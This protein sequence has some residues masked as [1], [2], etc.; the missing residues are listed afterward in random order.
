MGTLMFILNKADSIRNLV[1]SF[2][3]P[4]IFNESFSTWLGYGMN[5]VAI[6]ELVGLYGTL[7]KL[8][9]I[10]AFLMSCAAL[11]ATYLDLYDQHIE[12]FYGNC[13]AEISAI[14]PEKN[15]LNIDVNVSGYEP[16][17]NTLECGVV[18][19]KKNLLKPSFSEGESTRT[20]THNG[21]YIFVESGIKLNTAYS[22]RPFVIDKGR[23]SLWKGFIGDLIGPLVRY[24]DVKDIEIH[25]SVSTGDCISVEETAA[26]VKCS[27][28]NVYGAECGVYVS[29][30]DET[31]KFAASS[32]DG[33]QEI[34]LSGLR[35]ATTYNYWAYVNVDGEYINGQVKSF[36][37]DLPDVTGTWSCKE[38]R[39]TANGE[40]YN[41][42]TVTLHADG[43][44]T[45]SLYDDFYG[46]SWSRSATSLFVRIDIIATL[47]SNSGYNL[48]ITFDD[49]SH[50]N[51]G[52]GYAEQWNYSGMTGGSS[53]QRFDLEMKR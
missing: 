32:T 15:K 7:S 35:P 6:K 4:D 36:T 31:I 53:S 17:Y 52:K 5:V 1:R 40:Y 30:D 3:G 39:Y 8:S 23:A 38:T 25:P 18:V 29:N 16:W 9:P 28:T 51:S 12:A 10:G 46:A 45:T 33:E 26:V 47:Y 43:T 14:T 11:R 2:G 44:V 13:R 48:S 50:P 19:E 27:Y 37:T 22:C 42:Y 20:I 41:S 21:S 34:T 24:G 49:P